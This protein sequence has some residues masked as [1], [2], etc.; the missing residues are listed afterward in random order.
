MLSPHRKM[1]DRRLGTVTATEHLIDLLNGSRPIH[2]QPFRAGARAR[3]IAR[4]EIEKM[5]SQEVIEPETFKWASPIVLV[6]KPDGSLR[7]C[8][9]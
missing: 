5:L 6:P 9:Y 2:A 8:L 1:R 3:E 4:V 7:F